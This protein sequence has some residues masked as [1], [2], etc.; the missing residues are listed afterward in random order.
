MTPDRRTFIAGAVL[1][2]AISSDTSFK[3][4]PKGSDFPDGLNGFYLNVAGNYIN[5]S[6][7]DHTDPG[8]TER[9]AANTF[10]AFGGWAVVSVATPVST[11]S[12]PFQGWIDYC[13][14]RTWASVTIAR[15]PQPSRSLAA[16]RPGIT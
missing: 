16:N 1:G 10:V 5:A 6:L 7:G 14:T 3:V 9:I 4:I 13:S 12:T 2:L 8:I 11:I 15:R